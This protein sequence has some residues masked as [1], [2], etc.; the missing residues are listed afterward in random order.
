MVDLGKFLSRLRATN[1]QFISGVPD[2][3]LNDLCLALEKEW[4]ADRHVIAANEG[5]A[6]AL[7]SGWHLATGSVPLVYMQN[8][9]LGNCVNPLLSL[10]DRDMYSIPMILL[11]GWRGEPGKKDHVQHNKQG[12]LTPV[13]LESMDI[14]HRVVDSDEGALEAVD[15][16]TAKAIEIKG[17]VALIARKGVFERGEKDLTDR[18]SPYP[19]SREDVIRILLQAL[20]SDTVFVATTGR[21]TR[22]L[23]EVRNLLGLKH[24]ND[25]LNVGAMGHASSIAAG[26]ALA[27]KDRTVVCL[28]GDAAAFMHLGTWG[29]IAGLK[30]KNF[31]HI[32]INNGAHESVG[33]QASAGF[34]V[35]FHGLAKEAGY[36]VSE[37]AVQTEAAIKETLG[38]LMRQEGPSFLEVRIRKGMRS[39][40]PPLKF[41]HAA[42][43]KALMESLSKGR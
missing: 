36:R 19:L 34:K 20:P 24:D 1:V 22:E 7:A 11:I 5:C 18:G 6:I 30:P 17:P 16:A 4:P 31:L 23:H 28:D 40:M 2:T 33:G 9:G 3:L 13:L 37:G 41:D 27:R 14:P 26:I 29:T 42:S 21:A 12:K 8:S 10:T 39:D 35:N 32:V 38:V 25:F 43:K 15:W